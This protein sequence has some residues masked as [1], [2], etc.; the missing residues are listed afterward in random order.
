MAPT[1]IFNPPGVVHRVDQT[2]GPVLFGNLALHAGHNQAERKLS[3]LV[4]GFHS[5][6]V[7]GAGHKLPVATEPASQYRRILN[8]RAKELN[9]DPALEFAE[10]SV[11]ALLIAANVDG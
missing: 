11:K 7:I 2:I 8:D 3:A 10:A 5:V 1:F 9:E 4:Y 6:R